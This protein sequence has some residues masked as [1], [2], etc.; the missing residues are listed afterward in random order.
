MARYSLRPSRS[1][2]V[3]TAAALLFAAVYWAALDGSGV[4]AVLAVLLAGVWLWNGFRPRAGFR[5]EVDDRTDPPTAWGLLLG[6]RSERV[7]DGRYRLRSGRTAAVVTAILTAG[8]LA[9]G[10]F[11]AHAW[12]FLPFAVLLVVNAGLR[13]W[14][15]FGR[16]AAGLSTL[17]RYSRETHR[18]TP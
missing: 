1:Q 9:F 18:S 16:G 11:V 4:F 5:M 15:A 8:A 17:E 13:L 7:A 12:V 14:S 3:I 2:A 10:A 6:M